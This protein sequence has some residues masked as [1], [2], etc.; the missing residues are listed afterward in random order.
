MSTQ[1][2]RILDEFP[3]PHGES[4]QATGDDKRHSDANDMRMV[5]GIPEWDPSR[6]EYGV[7]PDLLS[8][9]VDPDHGRAKGGTDCYLRGKPGKGKS[10]LLCALVPRLIELNDETVWWRAS[11]S[12]SEWLPLA[13]WATVWI[14][15]GASVDA[16]LAGRDPTDGTISVDVDE[17][18]EIVRSVRRYSSPRDLLDKAGRA[19]LH[20]VYPDPLMR[21]CNS[22]L[23]A[24]A[25]K[26]Y[27]IPSGRD[28][29]FDE[30]DPDH[31]WWFGFNLE[32]VEN[33]PHYFS[34]W[35]CDELGD[36]MPQ[37]ASKDAFG[38][39]QKVQMM[40]D[41]WVDFRKHNH[42]IIAAGHSEKDA[43]SAIRRKLRWRIQMPG[44]AN[45]TTAGD[46]VGFESVPMHSDMTSRMPV[47]KALIYTET[48]FEKIAWPDVSSPTSHKLKITIQT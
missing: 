11:S 27:E 17:L 44:Q 10:T 45:P 24:A 32:R 16:R 26:E 30:R 37:D 4:W 41:S 34:T 20:V 36:L 31:H 2:R 21:G 19:R 12:R 18:G 28:Q 6:F 39:Y 3:T 7:V 43:H 25:E 42:T 22:A 23:E 35:I 15:E 38:W 48:N 40:K 29:L 8:H 46:L 33:G 14:P 9:T 1:N 13:R 47:G 5:H